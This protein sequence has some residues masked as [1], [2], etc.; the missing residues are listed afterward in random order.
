MGQTQPRQVPLLHHSTFCSLELAA[1]LYPQLP[2]ELVK[3]I[4]EYHDVIPLTARLSCDFADYDGYGGT[5]KCP[6]CCDQIWFQ[7]PRLYSRAQAERCKELSDVVRDHMSRQ[8]PRCD[9]CVYN[10]AGDKMK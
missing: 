9:I 7:Y 4:L 8:H 10:V 2:T 1:A 6:E 5:F 3:S